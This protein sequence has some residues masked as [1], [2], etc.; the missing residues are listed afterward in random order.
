MR[1][2]AM[3]LWPIASEMPGNMHGFVASAPLVWVLHA[4]AYGYIH[5]SHTISSIY[6]LS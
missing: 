3:P 2:A 5:H 4:Y 6:M 1:L